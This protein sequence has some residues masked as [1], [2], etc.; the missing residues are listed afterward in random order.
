MS[1][2]KA[3]NN[4]LNILKY[5]VPG[6][7]KS[8]YVKLYWQHELNQRQMVAVTPYPIQSKNNNNKNLKNLLDNQNLMQNIRIKMSHCDMYFPAFYLKKNV[9]YL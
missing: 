3:Q 1:I 4:V 6:S 9:I 7:N 5:D 2:L 8:E